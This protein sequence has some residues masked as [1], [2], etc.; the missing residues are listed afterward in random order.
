LAPRPGRLITFGAG[1]NQLASQKVLADRMPE[2]E[3][4]PVLRAVWAIL[5]A[6]GLSLWLYWN[7]TVSHIL[8]GCLVVLLAF[9]I[10]RL[11]L[12]MWARWRKKQH[13][14]PGIN[15]EDNGDPWKDK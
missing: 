10:Q 2:M 9:M 12:W 3:T 8:W 13:K 5:G 1:T 14:E 4:D 7:A 15:G 6:A 11:V